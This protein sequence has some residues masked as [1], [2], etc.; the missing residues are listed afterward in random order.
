ML[1]PSTP[2]CGAAFGELLVNDWPVLDVEKMDPAWQA[3]WLENLS[4][5][6]RPN[7]LSDPRLD[8]AFGTSWWILPPSDP[9]KSAARARCAQLLAGLEPVP[10]IRERV[11]AFQA[12]HFRSTMIGVHL[13][14]GDFVR[15]RPESAGNTG[16]ALAELDR[17]LAESPDA[18]IFLCTDDAPVDHEGRHVGREGVR[19]LLRARYGA[20]IVPSA[21]RSVDRRTVQGVQDALLDLLL[22]RATQ[23]V[24]GTAESAFSSLAIFGRSIPHVLVSGSTPEY[25]RRVRRARLSGAYWIVIGIARMLYGERMAFSLASQRL[26]GLKGRS[27]GRVRD[28]LRRAM[29]VRAARPR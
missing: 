16:E 11:A 25:R 18:G 27:M 23:V 9:E 2:A 29:T 1:W 22:L 28:A 12:R 5:R 3:R 4:V 8:L 26:S 21:A 13:R 6:K 7:P 10:P 14:R 15:Y 24:V 20:R 19:E 17:F